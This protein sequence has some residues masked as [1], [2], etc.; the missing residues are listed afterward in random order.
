MATT[1]A[2]FQN[3]AVTKNFNNAKL[4]NGSFL[5]V[6]APTG[7]GTVQGIAARDN[8]TINVNGAAGAANGIYAKE[9]GT[10]TFNGGSC[11]DISKQMN[12]VL[13]TG[14]FTHN[15]VVV[16]NPISQTLTANNTNRSSYLGV[17][18]SVPLI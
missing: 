14:N 1:T 8:A 17:V 10:V 12:G 5:N 16:I 11:T 9:R 18:S 13:T 2:T 6:N 7:V 3:M 15:N 4:D